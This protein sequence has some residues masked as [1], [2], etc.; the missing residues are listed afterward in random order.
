MEHPSY[1]RSNVNT[2]SS[3]SV[4]YICSRRVLSLNFFPENLTQFGPPSAMVAQVLC[5]EHGLTCP[6]AEYQDTT[7]NCCLLVPSF[8]LLN[9]VVIS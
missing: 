2:L 6:L 7:A 4:R 5:L 1:A 9:F 3:L 8:T